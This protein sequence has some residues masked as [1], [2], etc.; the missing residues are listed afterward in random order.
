[1][2]APPTAGNSG[3]T[4]WGW[5]NGNGNAGGNGG[6]NGGGNS[7]GGAVFESDQ[8][9][10]HPDHLGSSSYVTDIDGEIFQHVEY[11][12]FGET[13]FQESSNTQRTPYLF[14]GKELDEETGLYY[15]GARYYDPRTSVWQ[16]P[17]PILASY[18]QGEP[19][20]GILDSF[21]LASYSYSHNRPVDLVD[22]NGLAPLT[23]ARF[24][25]L[26]G[27]ADPARA[28]RAF[29]RL[30][31][32][33]LWD[34]LPNRRMFNSPYR[35]MRTVGAS[36]RVQPDAFMLNIGVDREG[37][38]WDGIPGLD[39]DT[40]DGWVEIIDFAEIKAVNRSSLPLS[41]NNYQISGMI[42]ALANRETQA[43]RKN[44]FDPLP[45]LLIVTTSDTRLGRSLY[46]YAQRRG[47]VLL[48]AW[49]HESDTTPGE[50]FVNW[51]WD[52]SFKQGISS[53][54]RGINVDTA[55]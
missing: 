25:Q 17:D 39:L 26:M 31:L 53:S 54:T 7:G 47:V 42:D 5:T 24:M 16:S 45:V 4:P 15:F 48:H 44:R 41:Y 32:R 36:R 19:N 1:V 20:G 29:E 8:Y 12:P 37:V 3:Q 46:R 13:F 34:A 6:G 18:M 28:G 38:R 2:V 49:A 50:I 33:S 9:F 51:A 27:I 10:Y 43:E 30:M 22:P 11:F 52:F 21:N 55:D 23:K 40:N 14:T 35:A